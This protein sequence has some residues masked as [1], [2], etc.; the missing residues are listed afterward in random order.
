MISI[1]DISTRSLQRCVVCIYLVL[2]TTQFVGIEGMSISP[3][4]A[5]AMSF[6]PLIF[7]LMLHLFRNNITVLVYVTIYMVMLICCS[8]FSSTVMVWDRIFYR[9][10]FLLTFICVYQIIHSG[11]V[12]IT[13]F[14]RLLTF[15]VCAYGCDF[16]LQHLCFLVGIHELPLI[17]LTG[18][19]TMGGGLKAN[20]LA[21]E[22]SHAARILAFVYWGEIVLTEIIQGKEMTITEHFKEAP[23]STIFFWS[24]MLLMG[25]ATAMLGATLVGIHFFKK[26][27]GFY[28]IGIIVM[29]VLL[30]VDFPIESLNRLKNVVNAFFSDDTVETL[31]ETE[32]SG[33]SRIAPIINTITDLDL[34]LWHSWVGQGSDN[35]RINAAMFTTQKIGDIN[36][37]GLISY[38][39][40]LLVVFKCCIRNFF[41][42][43][44]LLFAILLGFS[45]GSIYT[46]WGAMMVCTAIKYYSK[47]ST[48][49]IISVDDYRE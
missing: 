28:L 35:E 34:S 2:M 27:F 3:V 31:K 29:I 8:I 17:N 14:Q 32:S 7:I 12:S 43:E 41:C 47:K 19:M 18:A 1:N 46:C 45:I 30:N 36:D 4:K 49:A 26:Q 22:P 40:S 9:G 24:S 23:W 42:L 44:T 15:I 25:S 20:G 13:F 11:G 38:I 5:V 6:S 33:G 21:I 39:F 48:A 10:M 16:L 37:F